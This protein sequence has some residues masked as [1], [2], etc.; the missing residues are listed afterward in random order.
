MEIGFDRE[1]YLQMQAEHID[2]R[3]KQFGGKLYLEFGGKLFDDL[4]ASRVLPGFAPDDKLVMLRR[5]ADEVEMVIVISAQDLADNKM[6][7]DLGIGYDADVLRLIDEFRSR[8]LFV[9]SVVISH[10]TDDNKAARAFK[11]KLERQGVKVYRHFPIKGYPND[12]AHIVSPEGYGRNEYIETSRDLV[13]VTAPGPGSGK[14]ATC[15]S[16]L[17]H[18]HQRGISSGYA[19]FETFPIWNLPLDHPV[20]VAYE[21]ATV[22]LDDV[23]LI[24][25]FHLRT[26]GESCVNYNRDVEV[27]PVL[28]LLF[29]QIM[30]TSPYA[31]PTDMGVNMVG[32]CISDDDACVAA[33]RQEIL[34]R[35][36]KALAHERREEIEPEQSEKIALLMGRMGIQATDRPVVEPALKV[37]KRTKGPAAAIELPDGRIITG[38]T[39]SLLGC[40][41][42]IL[43]DALKALA[44]IDDG[45]KL[46][47]RETVVPI[48]EVKTRHLGGRNPRLHTDEVL[49]ALAVGAQHDDNARR[50][51]AELPKLRGCDVH[52]TVILG[53]VDEGIF[54]NLGVQVTSEPAYQTKKLY[55]KS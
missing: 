31:S 53:P 50:A 4:H 22:D 35:Y 29:E 12:V 11:R 52:S 47:A 13:V 48:Q 19:K 34:R 28:N 45:V 14:M 39:T 17:Y 54:R 40:C 16:Q 7:G 43:L 37:A 5:L 26:Y 30:E 3:R 44:G 21:A 32:H 18:D 38:K 51:L 1:K 24:D 27:F 6:R 46:L 23:N 41:S 49:I 2:A 20:N 36:Y 25:P 9:G 42:A 15:L 55:R 8:G 33:S 10:V